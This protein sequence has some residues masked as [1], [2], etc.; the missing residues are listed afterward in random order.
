MKFVKTIKFLAVCVLVC[1]LTEVLPATAQMC[2][3]SDCAA[4]GYNNT[5]TACQNHFDILKCPFNT[6]KAV[7]GGEVK[8][9]GP[10]VYQ[11]YADSKLYAVTQGY[12]GGI[13]Y[14]NAV[15]GCTEKG[16][17]LPSIAE[18]SRVSSLRSQLGIVVPIDSSS[19]SSGSAG[20]WTNSSCGAGSHM[21][22]Y[23]SGPGCRSNS[24]LVNG[25]ICV[26]EL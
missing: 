16:Y 10:G 5:A 6:A 1:L 4:L 18:V 25:V 19:V 9:A 2:L 14:D 21:I 3:K 11:F 7:C 17:R 23:L 12:M 20:L 13:S 8:S 24:Q 22:F 26:K 15:K